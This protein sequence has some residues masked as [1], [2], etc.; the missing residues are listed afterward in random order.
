MQADTVHAAVEFE[1]R[2]QR[3]AQLGLLDDLDLPLRMNHAPQVML[4]DQRQL[5]SLEEAFEQQD[6]RANARFAQ[7]QRLF[8]AGHG[9]A[10]G[11]GFECLRT[12]HRAM[13][14]GIGLD[15]GQSTSAA[16]FAGQ[17]VVVT[18]GIEVDQ[19]TGRTHGR[20]SLNHSLRR[21]FFV[22]R[23]QS[24]AMPAQVPGLH[25]GH[26]PA[27]RHSKKNRRGSRVKSQHKKIPGEFFDV[28]CDG[29]EG[30]RH[31]WQATKSCGRLRRQPPRTFPPALRACT[32]SP[33]RRR[34]PVH[35][36]RRPRRRTRR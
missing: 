9:K 7:Y 1:P 2:G 28:A 5:I 22:A 34:G 35:G 27:N 13:P 21:R 6:R 24:G 26:M 17:A 23:M 16:Q 29:P 3:L 12:A 10:V 15:H 8:D 33:R 32:S 18:Q 31:G 14:V 25:P 20:L 11:L 4:V 36:R 30:C 19:G